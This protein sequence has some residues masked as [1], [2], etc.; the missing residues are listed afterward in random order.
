MACAACLLAVTTLPSRILRTHLAHVLWP[1]PQTLGAAAA[2]DTRAHIFR[3]SVREAP[4]LLKAGSY[5]ED[6]S[7]VAH[8]KPSPAAARASERVSRIVPISSTQSDE[9]IKRL[10]KKYGIEMF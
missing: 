8:A 1:F 4:F 9:E 2:G 3:W 6:S 10:M 5:W 7:A